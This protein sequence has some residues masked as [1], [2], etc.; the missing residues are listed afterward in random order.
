[1]LWLSQ[2]MI[3]IQKIDTSWIAIIF[4]KNVII[5]AIVPKSSKNSNW[6]TTGFWGC[7][8]VLHRG[9]VVCYIS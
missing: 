6:D 2:M 3:A 7:T 8:S 9:H 1:M 4:E 5:Y